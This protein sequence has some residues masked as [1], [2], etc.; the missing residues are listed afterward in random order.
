MTVPTQPPQR[1]I[2]AAPLAES[3]KRA[4]SLFAIAASLAVATTGTHAG[5]GAAG[6]TSA[7]AKKPAIS[8]AYLGGI[9][10][11]PQFFSPITGCAQWIGDDGMPLVMSVPIKASSLRPDR[12][13]VISRAGVESTP[14]CATLRPADETNERHTILLAGPIADPA[15]LPAYVV[16]VGPVEDVRG[17][18]LEGAVSPPVTIGIRSGPSLVHAFVLN[19]PDGPPGSSRRVIQMVWQGGVTGPN[20]VEV[21]TEQLNAIRIID[22]NGNAH[23]P[24]AFDDLGDGDNYLELHLPAGVVAERVEVAAGYF[25]DPLNQPNPTTA[26]QVKKGCRSDS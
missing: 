11:P 18:V 23:T 3:M 15:D 2:T 10:V 4:A 24:L 25:F 7:T 9:N 1:P 14:N 17:N 8:S 22:C 26:V 21:G 6:I 16:I 19:R 5:N 20:G 12:F 13:R